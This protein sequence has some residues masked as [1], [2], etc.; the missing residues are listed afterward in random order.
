M[1]LRLT[2][3]VVECF[4]VLQTCSSP[5][6]WKRLSAHGNAFPL[7]HKLYN[8]RLS[9]PACSIYMY[10]KCIE[11]KSLVCGWPL[12][13]SVTTHAVLGAKLKSI[14]IPYNSNLICKAGN[15][16]TTRSRR[17]HNRNSHKGFVKQFLYNVDWTAFSHLDVMTVCVKN[18]IIPYTTYTSTLYIQH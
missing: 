4:P 3:L 17:S 9:F 11:T 15:S 7:L 14:G 10:L 18:F 8:T 13:S 1:L 16:T 6:W 5:F 2:A 12:V